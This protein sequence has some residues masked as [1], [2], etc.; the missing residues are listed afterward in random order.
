MGRFDELYS[1]DQRR[2]V[3][4]FMLDPDPDT[5][6]RR[7][8]KAAV[9]AL[10][11]GRLGVSPP[12][13]PMPVT[14]AY[15]CRDRER[16]LRQG[17][18]LTD[19]AKHAFDNPEQVRQNLAQRLLSIHE[20]QVEKLEDQ[21]RKGKAVDA[22]LYGMVMKN[23]GNV[24]AML[25]QVQGQQRKPPATPAGEPERDTPVPETDELERLVGEHERTARGTTGPSV[26]VASATD[27]AVG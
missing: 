23:N 22:R 5:G 4:S 21:L 24:F 7:T 26:S 19:Q 10:N 17:D 13:K 18:K 12:P 11:A 6:K 27:S 1:E 20:R 3:G 16:Q 15:W 25:K 2:A 9:A 14:T 8:A